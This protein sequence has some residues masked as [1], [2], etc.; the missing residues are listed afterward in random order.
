[1]RLIS[2]PV[3]IPTAGLLPEATMAF[4]PSQEMIRVQPKIQ[5]IISGPMNARFRSACTKSL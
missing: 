4:A 3:V 5:V 1:M 2:C